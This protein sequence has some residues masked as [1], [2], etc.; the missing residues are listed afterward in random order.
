MAKKEKVVSLKDEATRLHAEGKSKG[1]AYEALYNLH[2]ESAPYPILE[3]LYE[4]KSEL[5]KKID[6]MFEDKITHEQA[7]NQLISDGVA[8]EEYGSYLDL[9]YKKKKDDEGK[10]FLDGETEEQLETAL[11]KEARLKLEKEKLAEEQRSKAIADEATKVEKAEGDLA[12]LDKSHALPDVVHT[13]EKE[14]VKPK[15]HKIE[16]NAP[17]TAGKIRYTV[18]KCP[19]CSSSCDQH[20][21]RWVCTSSSCLFGKPKP[22]PEAEVP[23]E[24]TRYRIRIPELKVNLTRIKMVYVGSG[25]YRIKQGQGEY[26]AKQVIKLLSMKT[27]K[28]LTGAQ[29]EYLLEWDKSK[30]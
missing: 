6:K 22:L 9:V 28:Q 15:P 17:G 5:Q 14:T 12:P 3:E 2:F 1:E 24:I 30:G 29:L 7:E 8:D 20:Q 25:R 21:G 16:E 11:E 27:W 13:H 10:N 23:Q 18:W 4:T 26:I 19:R